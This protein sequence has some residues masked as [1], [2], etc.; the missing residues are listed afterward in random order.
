MASLSVIIPVYNKAPFLRRC[1]NSI[2]KQIDRDTQVII[3]DDGSTDGSGA[4]CNEYKKHGFEVHHTKNR[5][6]SEARNLGIKY[7]KGEWLTFMDADDAYTP[8]AFAIMKKFA[9]ANPNNIIQFGHHRH[10]IGHT[11]PAIRNWGQGTYR[12]DEVSR[13]WVAVWN[14]MY[15][16]EF[17]K[18]I[19][20]I[21]G[22]QFGEDEMFII[23]CLLKNGSL[24]HAPQNLMHH[25]FDDKE[26][27]TRKDN[28]PNDKLEGLIVQL[29]KKRDK[30]KDQEQKAWLD[31]IIAKHLGSS[32]FTSRNYHRAAGKYDVV[33]FLKE[34]EHNE[35]LRYSLRSV[36]KNL[37]YHKVI[38][39]G[40]CPVNLKPDY[41]F[42]RP[43]TEASK[44][45]RVRE[46]I[47][48]CCENDNIT[49][50]F[51]LFN[52]DFFVM[53]PMSENM[54]PQYNGD[55]KDRIRIVEEK[56]GYE[57]E[58]TRR[59]KHLV[60][61]LETAGKGTKNYAVHKPMLINRKKALEVLDKFPDEPMFRA[62]YGNYWKIGG[63]SKH[64]MK[65]RRL[66]CS[67]SKIMHWEFISTQDDSFRSGNVGHWVRQAFPNKSR[68]EV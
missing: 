39:Y 35:E 62:L 57:I 28:L 20:F 3:I 47:R 37:R 54:P 26:S 17:V 27:L 12:Y 18:P 43:Q 60:T 49:E 11:Y 51:W 66:T 30:L 31:K 32:T 58:W 6:V 22:L 21:K 34:A 23:E 46:S 41:Y 25:Y 38:F 29:E 56:H 45:E 50:D 59:L 63:V 52:D 68:F 24:Y 44:W 5:G 19:K 67:T 4:I 65:V 33:Y 61:T 1:L 13:Q 8:D 40:G 53:K 14:K 36:E 9:D 7:A 15:K 55:L 16:T 10:L 42:T 48:A 64:D 2:V